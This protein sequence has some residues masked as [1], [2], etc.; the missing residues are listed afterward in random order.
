MSE[1]AINVPVLIV[2][3]SYRPALVNDQHYHCADSC[4]GL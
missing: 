1:S 2:G 4:I 3:K